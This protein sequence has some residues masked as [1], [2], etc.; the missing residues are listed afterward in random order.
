MKHLAG[1]FVY[2][3][4]AGGLF[5]GGINICP[6]LGIPSM[7]FIEHRAALRAGVEAKTYSYHEVLAR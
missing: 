7:F 2:A 3:V 1:G 5:I 4:M 6:L